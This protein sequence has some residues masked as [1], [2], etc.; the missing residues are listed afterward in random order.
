MILF[1]LTRGYKITEPAS[2]YIDYRYDQLSAAC[3]IVVY[4]VDDVCDN[5]CVPCLDI[6]ITSC[7]I[8][9]FIASGVG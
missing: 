9:C 3:N 6:G 1:L 4:K 7:V 8:A 5:L 2:E